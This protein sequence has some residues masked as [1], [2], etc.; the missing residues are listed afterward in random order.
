MIKEMLSVIARYAPGLDPSGQTPVGWTSAK[1]LE[2]ASKYLPGKDTLTSADILA[3]MDKVKN[4]DVGG[5]TAPLTF[6]EGQPAKPFVCWSATTI[7]K[8]AWVTA[9]KWTCK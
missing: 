5:M 6:T 1:L 4:Y 2:Y 3:S 8:G 7:R 9:S